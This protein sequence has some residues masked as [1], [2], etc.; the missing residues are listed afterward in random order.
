M[1]KTAV[2][3]QCNYTQTDKSEKVVK[4]GIDFTVQSYTNGQKWQSGK[5]GSDF[6]IQSY[7]NGQKWK[8]GHKRQWFYNAI[9]HKR[10]KVKKW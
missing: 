10:A 7:T 6:T 2:I 9:L 1:I 5:N 8:S 3:S 4:N